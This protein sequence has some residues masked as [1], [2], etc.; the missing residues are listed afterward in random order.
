MWNLY[1]FH[2]KFRY[3]SFLYKKKKKTFKFNSKNIKKN[4]KTF[5]FFLVKF[6]NFSF[7]KHSLWKL[8]TKQRR[9]WISITHHIQ[10]YLYNITYYLLIFILLLFKHTFYYVIFLSSYRGQPRHGWRFFYVIIFINSILLKKLEKI[11]LRM[12]EK[13]WLFL[14]LSL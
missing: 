11:I 2:S 5:L 12:L 10:T 8:K 14:V 7:W 6:S 1:L 3:P 4:P 9:I 13:A